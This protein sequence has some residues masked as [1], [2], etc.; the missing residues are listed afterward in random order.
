VIYAAELPFGWTR[1]IGSTLSCP[2][3]II[4]S[5]T[6]LPGLLV[7]VAGVGQKVGMTVYLLAGSAN[8][9]YFLF[10]DYRDCMIHAVAI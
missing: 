7:E 3:Q 8:P 9:F 5:P 2:H 4:H 6:G 1:G 10:F